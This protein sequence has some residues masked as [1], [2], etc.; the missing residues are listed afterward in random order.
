MSEEAT[1]GTPAVESQPAGAATTD[2]NA[3]ASGAG[4]ATATPPTKS[5]PDVYDQAFEELMAE[6]GQP[7]NQA[8]ELLPT[9]TKQSTESQTPG[10]PSGNGE[11]SQLSPDQVQVLKRQHI[12]PEMVA[13]WSEAQRQS[14][15]ENASKRE[16]DQTTSYKKLSD[17][18]DELSK[19][20]DDGGKAEPEA[21]K[22]AEGGQATPATYATEAQ[23]VADEL[24][25]DFGQEAEGA[26]KLYVKMGGAVDSLT[27]QIDTLQ[28]QIATNDQTSNVQKGLIV[29]MTLENGIRDL[30]GDYP[31]LSKGEVRKQVNDRFLSDWKE[32][33]NPHR[34]GDGPLLD[35]IKAGQRDAAKSVLGTKT[36]KAAQVA[37]VNKTKE[38]LLNQPNP[39]DGKGRP[40]SR[41]QEDIYDQAF[42]E[43]LTSD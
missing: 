4:T 19:K 25:R 34:V 30:V 12:E 35:R 24:V 42:Q 31:S 11:A 7:S 39:G 26:G 40:V 5:E 10:E 43:H 33:N 3:E 1:P 13:G 8:G 15:F 20:V 17:Q 32:E 38:R 41:S 23:G 29:Q 18:V 16:A 28:K 22:Q 21:G 2:A 37:L 27:T 6:D 9:A 14:F 36:E